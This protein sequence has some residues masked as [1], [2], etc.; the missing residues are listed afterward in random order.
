VDQLL[1]CLEAINEAFRRVRG[2]LDAVLYWLDDRGYCL[3]AEETQRSI[4]QIWRQI[5]A[6]REETRIPSTARTRLAPD[7][8]AFPAVSMP[9]RR[10]D[11][12]A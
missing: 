1:A 7:A 12:L 2:D 11:E 8:G 9:A 5:V 4:L 10:T 6:A 3:I